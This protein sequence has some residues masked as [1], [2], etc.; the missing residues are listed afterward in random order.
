MKEGAHLGISPAQEKVEACP[1]KAEAW[2]KG[3]KNVYSSFVYLIFLLTP[4]SS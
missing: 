2:R 1:N 3:C 4:Y